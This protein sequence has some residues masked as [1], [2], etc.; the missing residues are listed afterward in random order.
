M[1]LRPRGDQCGLVLTCEYANEIES[2]HGLLLTVIEEL[3][4]QDLH[5]LG[6]GGNTFSNLIKNIFQALSVSL[7]YSQLTSQGKQQN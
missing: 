1:G 4:S 3:I 2:T 6:V 7:K 5:H